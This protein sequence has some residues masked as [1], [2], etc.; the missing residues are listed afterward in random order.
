MKDSLSSPLLSI[1]TVVK[2]DLSGLILTTQ[3]ILQQNNI[4]I[5]HIIVD[6]GSTD[7]SQKYALEHSDIH[8]E[9]KNDGGIY[10]G[11]NRGGL[12]AEGRFLMFLNSGDYFCE[13]DNL[14]QVMSLMDKESADWG[15]GPIIEKTLRNTEILTREATTFDVESIAFRKTFVPFPTSIYLKSFYDSLGGVQTNY[16]IAGDFELILKATLATKPIYWG[17][18]LVN[19]AAGGVSY[20][21]APLSWEEEHEIRKNLLKLTNIRIFNSWFRV[22][23]RK[24]KWWLGKLAD[25]AYDKGLLKGKHWRDLRGQS[26]NK[27]KFTSNSS[28]FPPDG[29]RL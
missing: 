27:A 2:D 7:G 3:S 13:R 6:G 20:S 23:L 19:F 18:P 5:Q 8:V 10:F 25:F 24:S 9:S 12:V 1:V 11:M 29:G 14:S 28:Y 17:V 4:T 22:Q 15:F 16:R 26:F 21:L